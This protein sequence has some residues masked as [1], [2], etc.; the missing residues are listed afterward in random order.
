MECLRPPQVDNAA[1]ETCTVLILVVMECL[2]PLLFY[3]YFQHHIYSFF[4]GYGV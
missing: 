2:R 4:M 3:Y 1:A